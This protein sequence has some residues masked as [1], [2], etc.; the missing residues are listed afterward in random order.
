MQELVRN[1]SQILEKSYIIP[2]YQR[3]FN[4]GAEEINQFLQD[5]YQS[6]KSNSKQNYYI[7]NLI[8]FKRKRGKLN[9]VIDGQQRLTC[10]HLIARL[11][12]DDFNFLGDLKYDSRG[13]VE[14]FFK[15]L[16][17]ERQSIKRDEND[18]KQ[19]NLI[20]FFDAVEII[21][22]VK[23]DGELDSQLTISQLKKE[24]KIAGFVKYFLNKVL[25]LEIDMPQDTDVANYFEI[26]N[27]RGRQ[28]QEHEIL[29]A[30]LM[31]KLNGNLRSVFGLVWDACSQMD[32]PIQKFFAPEQRKEL[33]GVNYNE[34]YPKR[35]KKLVQ[36]KIEK[37]SY[38][39]I[40]IFEGKV[41][42]IEKS[43]LEEH[44]DEIDDEV[45]Y[46]AIID[47]ANFLFHVLKLTYPQVDIPLSSDKLIKTYNG[48]NADILNT[49]PPFEF[50]EKLFF[51]RVV[52]DRFIVKSE[53]ENEQNQYNEGFSSNT[54]KSRWMLTK[55][56]MYWKNN[57]FK[58]RK[59]QSLSFKYTFDSDLQE[60]IVKLL[61][62]L[63]VT[64]RQRK[65]KNYLQFILGLFYPD[66]PKSIEIS[67]E[68]F[69]NKVEVFTLNQ[70]DKLNLDGYL[71]NEDDN[72][73]DKKP[74]YA[75]GTQ[76]PHFVFNFID[77]LYWVDV[78][79][80]KATYQI[81][82]DFDFTYRNSIEHHYPQAMLDYL[83]NKT[84]ED[85]KITLN[86]L[87]NLCLISKGANSKLNDREPLGK[88][89]DPRFSKGILTPKR[90]IMY[91]TTDSFKNW[92]EK[93]ILNHYFDVVT[94]LKNR[95][96]ILSK[97]Q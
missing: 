53:V 19:S 5:I 60:R 55:P 77:Y 88:S 36:K 72:E 38:S 73:N 15:R 32:R 54:G 78:Y 16:T 95:E 84:I 82:V 49:V 33:F 17:K 47:F 66:K 63:Q 58:S 10:I 4:W 93:Q 61:S 29:K 11:I 44:E 86:C 59:Y 46:T 65:N 90:R 2:L 22:N 74:I 64:Y 96:K 85:K 92:N 76:T 97:S 35:L 30:R 1:I 9:E 89:K 26:M 27:N 6:F 43:D 23:L 45:K 67:A 51:Y 14:V 12:L 71:S 8:T 3:N 57:A 31:S 34:V 50:L 91:N 56:V 94:L 7:G 39:I 83:D 41:D 69:L 79:T 62:M 75:G 20:S 52:F 24:N 81:D 18:E 87:G 37:K 42:K 68:E 70:F 48:I 21:T 80:N 13:E 25:I 40:Q 28:L